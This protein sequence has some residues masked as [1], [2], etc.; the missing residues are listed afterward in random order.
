MILKRYILQTLWKDPWRSELTSA[1]TELP[2][3]LEGFG[4]APERSREAD[5]QHLNRAE[6]WWSSNWKTEKLMWKSG[7]EGKQCRLLAKLLAAENGS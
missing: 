1:T 7:K 3:G 2:S 5:Q 4:I 6:E